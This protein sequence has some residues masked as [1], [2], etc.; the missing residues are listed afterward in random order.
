MAYERLTLPDP[1][2][3]VHRIA[4]AVQTGYA[5]SAERQRPWIQR[6]HRFGI[7]TINSTQQKGF[8]LNGKPVKIQGTCNHQDFAGV[9]IAMPDSLLEWRVRKLKAMG[10]NAYRM[11]HNPPAAELLDACDRLGMLVMD[12]NRHLGDTYTP[13]RPRGAPATTCPT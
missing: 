5:H 11:S 13:K 8:F 12:E 10:S 2:L 4:H 7:R 1:K 9:G 6:Q 3:L